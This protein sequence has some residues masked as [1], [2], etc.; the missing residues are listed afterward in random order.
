M[1]H[2]PEAYALLEKALR[3]RDLLKVCLRMQEVEEDIN[4]C[5]LSFNEDRDLRNEREQLLARIKEIVD[6]L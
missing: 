6:S 4:S 2:T 3:S 1:T 5:W